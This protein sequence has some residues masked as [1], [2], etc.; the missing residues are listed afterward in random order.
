M[1]VRMVKKEEVLS[2]RFVWSTKA[3]LL[4]QIASSMRPYEMYF[5]LTPITFGNFLKFLRFYAQRDVTIELFG[6]CVV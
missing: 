5:I 6:R 2:N 4:L 1:S 3:K